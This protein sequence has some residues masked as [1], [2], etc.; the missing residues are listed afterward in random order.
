VNTILIQRVVRL[1]FLVGVAVAAYI[2]L[3]FFDHGARADSGAIDQLAGTD[4]VASVMSA[5]ADVHKAIPKPK[6]PAPKATSPKAHR[7]KIQAPKIQA[8]KIQVQT[9]KV[10]TRKIEAPKV[11][12][13]EVRPPKIQA[14]TV[15]TPKDARV[16]AGAVVRQVED[17]TSRLRQHSSDAVRDGV[18]AAATR[19]RAAVVQL[20][21]APRLPDMPKPPTRLPDLPQPW[22]PADLPQPWTPADLPQPWTPADLPQPWTPAELP[23]PWTPADL[24]LPATPVLTMP[25]VPMAAQT[26]TLAVPVPAMP[27]PPLLARAPQSFGVTMSPAFLQLREAG[28]EPDRDQPRTTRHPSP[29]PRQPVYRSTSTGQARDSGAGTSPAMGTVS[30][31]WRPEVTA[32]GRPVPIDLIAR[33]R[34]VRY[35]GPPS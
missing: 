25:D 16:A 20:T 26:A 7:P 18:K 10:Q 1:F 21:S 29:P 22:T 35:A 5:T 30:S 15:R 32:A 2:V 19:T 34:T 9:P 12:V 17:Q 6:A 3:S 11:Q 27:Q 31:S 13:P 4:P 24:P 33:G 14:P 28:G 23:Q 8:P